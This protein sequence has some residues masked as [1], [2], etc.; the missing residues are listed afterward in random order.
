MYIDKYML[1]PLKS[2]PILWVWKG[3]KIPA[4]LMYIYIHY[5]EIYIY[6]YMGVS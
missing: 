3:S 2:P 5:M 4:G 6:I 1:P